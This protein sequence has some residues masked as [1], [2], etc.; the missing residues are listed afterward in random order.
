M[1]CVTVLASQPS[2]NIA[3]DTTFCRSC[4]IWPGLPTVSTSSR[5]TSSFLVL[6]ACQRSLLCGSMR[7]ACT[8]AR[9][10]AS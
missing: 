8:M 3:T 7:A 9:R 10:R 5:S 2:D 1:M 6:P 4:P